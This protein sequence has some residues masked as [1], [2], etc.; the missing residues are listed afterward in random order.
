MAKYDPLGR[1]LM[2][3]SEDEVLLTFAQ[4]EGMIGGALP[5]SARNHL[6]W[7]ANETNPRTTHVQARAWLDAG[8]K[9]SVDLNRQRVMFRR[10]AP[11]T[12]A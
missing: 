7:W 6:E 11:D 5:A 8:F 9:T 12:A 4:I 10:T 2:Q 3:Q 1:H